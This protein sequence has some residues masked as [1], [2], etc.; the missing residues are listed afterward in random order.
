M[1]A[2]KNKEGIL[3]NPL[4][5]ERSMEW[6]CVWTKAIRRRS[7]WPEFGVALA[8]VEPAAFGMLK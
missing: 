1:I 2:K 6:S 7:Y 8:E 5:V 3:A 4:L